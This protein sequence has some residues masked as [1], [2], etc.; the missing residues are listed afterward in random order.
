MMHKPNFFIIGAPKCGTTAMS[1]YL[2]S[3]PNVFMSAQKEPN[4]FSSDVEPS[5][6][7]FAE[8]LDLF[9]DASVEE[10]IVSEASTTYVYSDMALP[11]IKE[12]N[13]DAKLMVMLR[14]PT[15]LAYA[16]Y[17]QALLRGVETETDF[18]RAWALQEVRAS[19]EN[20]PPT[21]PSYKLLQYKWVASLGSQLRRLFKVFPKEQVHVTLMDDFNADPRH[22]YLRVLSFLDLPDD[23]RTEFPRVNEAKSHKWLWLGHMSRQL[24][25]R[26]HRP[27]LLIRQKTN[28]QGTGLL[29]MIN[30][31]NTEKRPRAPLNPEFANYLDELFD[32]EVKLL[33]ELLERD[34]NNW[35]DN[36]LHTP[37]CA[38]N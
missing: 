6:K 12:F 11:R 7:T 17:G 5:S 32:E 37:S 19:G 29:K 4:F 18:E 14:K 33:E 35:R 13:P 27:Y 21:C 16:A 2:R 9:K 28:F 26:L 25:R 15:D 1:E 31:F 3:H 8:Y 22:E 36:S 38:Y 23:G 30:R 34:L 24:R 20:L 10:R